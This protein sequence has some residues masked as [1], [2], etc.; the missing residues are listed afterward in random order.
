MTRG[1]TWIIGGTG[2]IL[3]GAVGL[4][5][6]GSVGLAGSSILVTVQNVVFAA[7]V[8]LLAVGM[9]RADSV[10]AR[11][12]TGVVALAVLAVW[13]FVADGAVAAVGSVQPNGGAGWAVLGYASLLIP[14]AAGLVGA[15]AILRAGAVPEPWRWAPLWAFALQ[16]G[17]WALTQALAVA[18]GA[19]VLSVSGVF[20]LLGA[21]AFLT[22]TV[23]LGVV[24]VILGARRRGATVEVFRSPPGR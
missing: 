9:R 12:P 10:V 16:V 17:V 7:S 24:A 15:V 11:R 1:T 5:G 3:S 20:V 22:G 6:A 23:G 8:L 19:D 13:P 14:T 21:V 4:L 18:L 2:L